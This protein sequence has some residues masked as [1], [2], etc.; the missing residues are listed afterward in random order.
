MWEFSLGL[1]VALPLAGAAHAFNPD[2]RPIPVGVTG[3]CSDTL[4]S[5]TPTACTSDFDCTAPALCVAKPS[6]VVAGIAVRGVLTLITDE[7]VTGWNEGADASTGRDQNARLTVML[8][9]TKDGTTRVFAETYK[10]E[11]S[12]GGNCDVSGEPALCVPQP[13]A[14]WFQPASEATLIFATGDSQDLNLQWTIPGAEIAKAVARDLT[15]NASSTATPFLEL[16]DDLDQSDHQGS[17]PVASVRRLKVTI[18]LKP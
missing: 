2:P 4:S 16:V 6:T 11:A 13:V 14:G 8:E 15:G 5:A 10:L 9:Y 7:D 1:V 18:R 3:A 12:D 17:D